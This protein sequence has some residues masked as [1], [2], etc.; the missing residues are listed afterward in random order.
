YNQQYIP[1][2]RRSANYRC[3][4]VRNSK[5]PKTC[6]P[7]EQLTETIRGLFMFDNIKIMGVSK[8]EYLAATETADELKLE[9]NDALAIDFMKTNNIN[10]IYSFDEDF[11][12]VPQITRLP[13]P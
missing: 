10:E 9:A 12:R 1:R 8:E 13:K 6:M 11:D 5:H 4:S 2:K 3:P 7:L